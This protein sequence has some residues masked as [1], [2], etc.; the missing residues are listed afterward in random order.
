MEP[1]AFDRLTVKARIA[2]AASWWKQK[3]SDLDAATDRMMADPERLSRFMSTNI[4]HVAARRDFEAAL[5]REVRAAAALTPAALERGF[6]RDLRD[7][8]RLAAQLS[9]VKE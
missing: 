9:K 7:L 6:A 8:S 1:T 4:E 5:R 2:K 3:V